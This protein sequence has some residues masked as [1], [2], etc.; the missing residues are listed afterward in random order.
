MKIILEILIAA[1]D[2][3]QQ[4][5]V[6]MLFGFF[7]AG[8]LYAYVKTEKIARYLG[9]KN[10]RSV[11]LAALAGI[12][13]PLCSCGVVPAAAALKKQGA[14]KGATLSFLISTPE[15]GVDS[16]PITYALLDPVMTMIRPIAA[17]VSATVAGI[18][19]NFYG[20]K[21]EIRLD[22]K[23][24]GG[25][26]CG[27]RNE[28]GSMNGGMQKDSFR[29]KMSVGI[30]YAFVELMGDIGPWFILG[31]VLAGLITYLLPEGFAEAYLGNP[32]LAMPL[33]LIV[34]IP[35]YV[36]ATSSTP[37]AAALI[38]K[39]LSPGA[40]LVFLLAGPATN[41][42][43]LSMV[44]R[45]MGKRSLAIYL[46][47][48]SSCA[49]VLGFLTDMVYSKLGISAR[50][51][52]GRSAELFPESVEFAAAIVLAILIGYSVIKGFR[53]GEA[54]SCSSGALVSKPVERI[55]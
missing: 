20:R 46:G 3:F 24:I 22:Q 12:P 42:A 39:G 41:M 55:F 31:I 34:G 48:I 51:V 10:G 27:C 7:M 8:I 4:S 23:H 25:K 2:I 13:L 17:F 29:S 50:A 37:I 5:A 6:Y 52:A 14:S 32:L 21:D 36:C 43:S 54:C 11:V 45:L 33:M 15:T 47:A 28:P 1:W 30:K 19:E 49:L 35:M 26:N 9:G 40:A 38:L 53:K 16:I 18:V 44:S